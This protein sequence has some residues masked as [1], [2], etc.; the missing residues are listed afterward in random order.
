MDLVFGGGLL[1]V[2]GAR[3]S[4]LDGVMSRAAKIV[5]RLLEFEG[6]F[7][8][9]LPAHSMDVHTSK[10]PILKLGIKVYGVTR[11]RP[12]TFVPSFGSAR[13]RRRALSRE[14]PIRLAYWTRLIAFSCAGLR[15]REFG[16]QRRELGLQCRNPTILGGKPRRRL[17]IHGNP[18]FQET[19]LTQI[20]RKMRR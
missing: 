18:L 12:P 10:R 5:L 11:Q 17:F 13:R 9:G 4:R 20:C 7:R 16:R 3:Q 8:A 19:F 14:K 15:C 6:E 2:A 1:G